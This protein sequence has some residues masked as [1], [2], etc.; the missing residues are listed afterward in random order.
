MMAG[1]RAELFN[2]RAFRDAPGIVAA[3]NITRGE[4]IADIGSG[5]GYLTS[6]FAQATGEEGRVFAVDTNHE[7]LAYVKAKLLRD[8]IKNIVALE[9][10]EEEAPL[11]TNSCDLIFL[12]NVFHHLAD[13]RAWFLN[14][15]KGLKAAGRI[16]IV[17][18]IREEGPAGRFQRHGTPR[19][20]IQEALMEAGFIQRAEFFFLEKQSFFMFERR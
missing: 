8:G 15:G 7:M 19:L 10:T 4:T 2:L 9:A 14:T 3:L 12:R 11:P 13:P 5:G 18:R 6:L 17:E 20:R 1:L 16:A